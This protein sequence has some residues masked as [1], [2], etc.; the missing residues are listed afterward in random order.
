MDKYQDREPCCDY[1]DELSAK[2]KNQI[3]VIHALVGGNPRY[4]TLYYEQM[5]RSLSP[6]LLQFA[7]EDKCICHETPNP[8]VFRY[9]MEGVLLAKKQQ[10]EG[11]K[12]LGLTEALDQLEKIAQAVCEK[13]GVEV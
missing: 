9:F 8:V 4:I 13:R 5:R 6:V 2:V 11:E 7:L 1:H 10:K 3:K 12:P